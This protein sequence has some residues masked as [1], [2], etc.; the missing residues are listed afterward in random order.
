MICHSISLTFTPLG[1]SIPH[2]IIDA[3]PETINRLC[4]SHSGDDDAQVNWGLAILISTSACF[5]GNWLSFSAS[6]ASNRE[7]Y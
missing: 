3:F 4:S 7:V 5:L 2:K 6:S 1:V